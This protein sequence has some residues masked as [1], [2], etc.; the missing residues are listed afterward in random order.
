MRELANLPTRQ[1]GC[2]RESRQARHV[3]LCRCMMLSMG[4]PGHKFEPTNLQLLVDSIPALIHTGLPDGYL[5]FFNQSWL[6]YVGRSLA[7]TCM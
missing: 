5:D 4:S 1:V 3:C 2:T 6:K 7:R